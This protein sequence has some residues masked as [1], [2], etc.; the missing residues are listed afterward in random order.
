MF[1]YL[2]TLMLNS[3]NQVFERYCNLNCRCLQVNTVGLEFV[4]CGMNHIEGG[5]SKDI[6]HENMEQT[7]RFR[8][9]AGKNEAYISSI[10]QLGRVSLLRL[11]FPVNLH[12]LFY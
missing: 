12:F 1:D 3:E 9:K 5:W 4:S 11:L 7:I 10:L 8:K 2:T 6:D